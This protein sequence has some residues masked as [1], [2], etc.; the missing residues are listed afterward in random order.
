MRRAVTTRSS[1][2]SKRRAST[3]TPVR[4]VFYPT[5]S[6]PLSPQQIEML[7]LLLMY[8]SSGPGSGSTA[9]LAGAIPAQMLHAACGVLT[10][11][12]ARRLVTTRLAAAAGPAVGRRAPLVRLPRMPGIRGARSALLRSG[13]R[14]SAAG[15]LRWVHRAIYQAHHRSRN[16]RQPRGRVQVHRDRLRPGRP[17]GGLGTSFV[18]ALQGSSRTRRSFQHRRA[19]SLQAPG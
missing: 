18:R 6:T 17:R 10:V 4:F 3:W 11:A 2:I 15:L 12:R 7:Y 5:T 14:W 19:R 13:R 9:A 16:L 8:L 1:T